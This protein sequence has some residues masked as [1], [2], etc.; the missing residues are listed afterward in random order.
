MGL[1]LS[2]KRDR[3]SR[4]ALLSAV[5]ITETGDK[6]FLDFLLGGRESQ[7]SSRESSFEA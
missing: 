3:V 2:L 7:V 1:N 4:E 6:E 5:E